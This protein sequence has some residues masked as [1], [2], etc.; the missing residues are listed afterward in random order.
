MLQRTDEEIK[1][2]ECGGQTDIFQRQLLYT[3]RVERGQARGRE[4][5]GQPRER[6][7]VT[8]LRWRQKQWGGGEVIEGHLNNAPILSGNARCG[9]EGAGG[10]EVGW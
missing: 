9:K 4:I 8:D 7:R 2:A 6:W 1:L 5:V 3:Y 10:G